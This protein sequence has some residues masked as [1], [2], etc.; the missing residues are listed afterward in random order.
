M[1]PSPPLQPSRWAVPSPP[2]PSPFSP[3]PAALPTGSSQ[4]RCRPIQRGLDSESLQGEGDPS[5]PHLRTQAGGSD[6]DGPRLCPVPFP[7]PHPPLPPPSSLS[8]LSSK[9]S[10]QSSRT[11]D[12][13]LI[14][15]SLLKCIGF[16]KNTKVA[17]AHWTKKKII[18]KQRRNV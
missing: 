16:L 2:Q 15:H 17:H 5:S 4:D 8:T 1:P 3:S 18:I 10:P 7:T 13:F 14:S 9:A 11:C 6:A 12:P